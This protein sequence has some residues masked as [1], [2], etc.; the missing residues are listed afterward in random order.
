MK[1]LLLFIV[2]LG[3]I[4]QVN[5]QD[6]LP[7]KPKN[8][9]IEIVVHR[10]A[11]HLAPE[12]T[13]ASGE[14]CVQMGLDFVEI[15]IRRS[16]DGVLYIMHDSS[17]DRTTN[18]KGNIKE[19]TSEQINALDAGS[20][21]SSD[22]KGEKVPQLEGYLKWIR[23][24][25]KVYL[26]VKDADIKKLTQLIRKLKMEKESFFWFG[27]STMTAEFRKIAPDLML[28]V[29]AEN[30]EQVE[31]ALAI[32]KPNIIECSVETASKDFIN[33]CH[34]KKL[35]VMV[36]TPEN[37]E[38]DFKRVIASEA[39]MINLDEPVRYLKALGESQVK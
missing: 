12:N 34:S 33:F 18:G 7:V 4:L 25:A 17:V 13:K 8:H 26:D 39:D 29:N 15:D 30:K 35:K 1:S 31:R 32:F 38:E 27:D 28:K 2:A 21:F 5:G 23:G 3:Y 11:N 16:K 20:W 36:Y 24:K 14:K 22:F 19:L 10:G 37:R 9:P 6:A